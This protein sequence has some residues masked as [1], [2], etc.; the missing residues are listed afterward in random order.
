M[1]NIALMA[2]ANKNDGTVFIARKFVA[3]ILIDL[4]DYRVI[5]F[6]IKRFTI[7]SSKNLTSKIISHLTHTI[8]LTM[9]QKQ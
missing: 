3:F 7:S 5:F 2:G 8:C 9:P 4:N 1:R 6:C